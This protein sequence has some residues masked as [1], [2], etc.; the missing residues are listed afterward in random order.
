[1]NAIKELYKTKKAALKRVDYLKNDQEV[2]A[3]TCDLNADFI[4]D[5][6]DTFQGV[7]QCFRIKDAKG[8][9]YAVIAYFTEE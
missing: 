5:E 1:M 7:T 6:V 4:S 3:S 8:D 9:D 2:E